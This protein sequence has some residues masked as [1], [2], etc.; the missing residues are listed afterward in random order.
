MDS[1]R[2]VN[3]PVFVRVLVH[4]FERGEG[5]IR[6]LREPHGPHEQG[7]LDLGT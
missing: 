1:R 4:R 3:K 2:Q 5:F 7:E 6:G